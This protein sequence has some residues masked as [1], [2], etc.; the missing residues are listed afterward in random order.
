MKMFKFADKIKVALFVILAWLPVGT[1]LAAT[2]NTGS[3]GIDLTIQNLLGILNGLVCIVSEAAIV[4]IVLALIFYGLQFLLS[5]GDPKKYQ[6]AKTAFKYGLIGIIIVIGTY[7]IIA[8]I[9]A[10]IG[11]DDYEN[12]SSL[13]P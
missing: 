7:T 5:K 12:M 1:S 3:P 10:A 6:D 4:I 8:T 11:G 13:C 9:Q 2:T